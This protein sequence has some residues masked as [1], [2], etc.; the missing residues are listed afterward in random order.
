MNKKNT[1]ESDQLLGET[2]PSRPNPQPGGILVLFQAVIWLQLLAAVL[3]LVGQ[4][5]GLFEY[6]WAVKVGLQESEA[7]IGPA[8]VQVNRAFCAADTLFYL[9]LLMSSVYGLFRQKRWSL[10][11]TA[12]SAGIHSYWSLTTLFIFFF[13]GKNDAPDWKY[14]PSTEIWIVVWLFA[15]YG[16]ALLT[17]LYRYWDQL[18]ETFQ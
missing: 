6:E 4:T 1:K 7:D 11:C 17:F 8:M 12:A 9:P 13:Q 5:T 15:I 2:V 3:L 14:N 18:F 10:I 16:V